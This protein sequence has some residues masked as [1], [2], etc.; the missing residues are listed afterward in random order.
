[1]EKTGLN[2]QSFLKNPLR[3][4]LSLGVQSSKP[5]KTFWADKTIDVF[6]L[7]MYTNI[8]HRFDFNSFEG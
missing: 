1:M 7:I 2:S 8:Y 4:S 3:C 5:T 6:L